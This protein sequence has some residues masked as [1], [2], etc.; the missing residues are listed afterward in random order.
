MATV[1]ARVQA[2]STYYRHDLVVNL[3]SQDVAANTSR[4]SYTYTI[5]NT[6]SLS[7]GSWNNSAQPFTVTIDGAV[8]TEYSAFDFRSYYSKTM[9]S[10]ERTITHN[11]DGTRSFVAR[12]QGSAVPTSSWFLAV[13]ASQTVYLPT[14]ARASSFS[15]TP[16]TVVDGGAVAIA[17]NRSSTAFT[18]DVTWATEADSGTIATGVATATSWTPPSVL[19]GGSDK[20][21]ITI[22]VTTKSG[23]TQIGSPVSRDIILKSPPVY[24]EVGLGTPFDVRLRRVIVEG[25]KLVPKENIPYLKLTTTDTLSASGSCTVTVAKGAYATALDEAV[26]LADM[27]DGSQW[28]PTGMLFVLSRTEG[29]AADMSETTN[30]TGMSY[31]DWLLSKNMVAADL[32]WPTVTPGDVI[33]QY[34]VIAQGRGWGPHVST[35]FSK[36]KTSVGT[37]W[38]NTDAP[39][40]SRGTPVS[41]LLQGFASDVLVEYNTSFNYT[42]GKAVVN[43]YNPGYGEDWAVAGSDHIVN[44]QLA[45]LNK[46]ADK[47]PIRK[48]AGDKMTRVFVQGDESDTTRESAAAVSPIFGHLEGSANASGVKDPARLVQLG[49]AVLSIN[50]TA[51]VERTFSYDLS[52]TQTPTH[53]FPYRTFKPGDWILIPG[54]NGPERARVSQVAITRDVEGTKATVTTG[55]LIPSGL[56]ATARKIAQSS[57]GAVSGGTLRAPLTLSSAIPAAPQNVVAVLDGYWDATGAPKSGVALSWTPVTVS[58]QGTPLLIDLYEVWTRAEEGSPFLL[59][60]LSDL[61]NVTVENLN[62]EQP[63]DIKVRGRSQDGVYGEYSDPISVVTVAPD[64]TLP[65]PA[66]PFLEVDALGTVSVSWSGTL[67]GSV[68]PAWFNFVRAEIS[69]SEFGAYSFAG[70]QLVSAGTIT[71]A[72]VGVGTWWFRLVGYDALNVRGAASAATEIEVVPLLTDT[73]QPNAPE[74]VVATSTGFWTGASAQSSI[75]VSWTAVTQATDDSLID[76]QVYEVWGKLSTDTTYKWLGATSATSISVTPVTPMDATWDIQVSATAVNNER[77]DFSAPVSVDIEPPSMAMD[78]PTKPTVSSMNGIIVVGWDG[79]FFRP[80]PID[81]NDGELY[82][83]PDF[84]A[85]VDIEVSLNDGADWADVGFMTKG[86]RKQSVSGMSVG[87]TL[88]VRLVAHDALNQASAASEA[89]SVVVVGIDGANLL[90][91]TVGSNHIIAGSIGVNLVEPGFG[92]DL[93]IAGNGTI[94]IISGQAANAQTAAQDAENSV[95]LMRTRYDFTPTEAVISQPGSPF[96]V[97]ISNTQMEF[98]ESGVA[99]AYLNAGVFTA[100]RMASGQIEFARH[101]MMDDPSG[102]GTVLRRK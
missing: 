33:W 61:P 15:V 57:G 82:P 8:D 44:L 64:E 4:V 76:I 49:D 99:R 35:T 3:L 69:D 6:R 22:K 36:T 97:A 63:L 84:V 41:Q 78:A 81:P 71:V 93:D 48:D 92:D 40:V 83:A 53:L 20:V 2:W 58:M 13:D 95:A 96:Q 67:G 39:K 79:M 90:P 100:P 10:G 9:V 47:A 25:G 5:T 102:A 17:I 98:R 29:D 72:N 87:S 74:D 94:S 23:A 88:L 66:T 18:H 14:I 26:V 16:N 32:D 70:Q 46:V 28:L 65:A 45:A 38:Q 30:Y 34:I 52:S 80:D 11:A 24:P 101:V 42:T 51:T 54:D 43:L 91:G 27:Y 73:R 12:M 55:D 85:S 56:A 7:V 50:R 19:L 75:D 1:I 59:A 37:A 86:D 77:S 68:P 31:A 21:S 89:T 62:I 60:T